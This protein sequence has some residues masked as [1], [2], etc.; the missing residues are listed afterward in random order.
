MTE[1]LAMLWKQLTQNTVLA[2]LAVL[3]ISGSNSYVALESSRTNANIENLTNTMM[4]ISSR[5]EENSY[6]IAETQ[7]D[8]LQLQKKVLERVWEQNKV[9]SQINR[10]T[11]LMSSKKDDTN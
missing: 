9:I 3:L 7:K 6:M 1:L 4:Q 11:A 8:M 10:N 5:S 2:F